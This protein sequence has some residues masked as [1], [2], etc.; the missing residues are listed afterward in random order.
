MCAHEHAHVALCLACARAL[1]LTS[2]KASRKPTP[3]QIQKLCG[4]GRPV[5]NASVM[6]R[7]QQVLSQTRRHQ[8]T[9]WQPAGL[10]QRTRVLS[11]H[12]PLAVQPKRLQALLPQR[13]PRRP[14]GRLAGPAGAGQ[15][16]DCDGAQRVGKGRQPVGPDP[17]AG[18]AGCAH[19]RVGRVGGASGRAKSCTAVLSTEACR[20][21]LHPKHAAAGRLTTQYRKAR[22]QNQHEDADAAKRLRMHRGSCGGADESEQAA[23]GEA[24]AEEDRQEG[25]VG[26]CASRVCR[27]DGWLGCVKLCHFA[28]SRG[29]AQLLQ[30]LQALQC[31]LAACI[32]GWLTCVARVADHPVHNVAEEQLQ[33][34]QANSNTGAAR[35]RSKHS[36]PQL[37]TRQAAS[38]HAHAC[39]A[40]HHCCV[41]RACRSRSRSLTDSIAVLSARTAAMDVVSANV[42][43]SRLSRT[44]YHTLRHNVGGQ[45]RMAA[46]GMARHRVRERCACKQA[47]CTC[48]VAAQLSSRQ[49]TDRFCCTSWALTAGSSSAGPAL[50][51]S[52]RP[53]T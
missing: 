52:Q 47:A 40:G 25:E 11:A 1:S 13:L 26:A 31:Q 16:V 9:A 6:A 19:A 21:E 49:Q 5:Q 53:G 22:C 51:R 14:A 3:A 43:M 36:R 30:P 24:Q 7:A 17:P 37:I 12:A 28:C 23:H 46:A 4:Q 48:R 42:G 15:L 27:E 41:L 2:V 38:A 39:A 34:Q 50:A 32:A 44:L 33:Q 35:R 45:T 8:C 29:L 10:H 18:D 20:R